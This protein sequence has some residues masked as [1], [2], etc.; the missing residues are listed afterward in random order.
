MAGDKVMPEMHLR[1]PFVDTH[2][3]PLLKINKELENL[4]IKAIY[5]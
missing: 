4:W 5:Q 3:G 1:D 2:S